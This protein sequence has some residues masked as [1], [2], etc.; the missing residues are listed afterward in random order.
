MESGSRK[1]AIGLIFPDIKHQAQSGGIG[2]GGKAGF[3][4]YAQVI[5]DV[6]I[7]Q[8]AIHGSIYYVQSP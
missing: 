6:E 8:M 1:R 4:L 2:H 7:F 5:G 3:E